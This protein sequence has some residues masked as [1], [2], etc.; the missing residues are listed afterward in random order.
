MAGAAARISR[1]SSALGWAKSRS[2]RRTA[3]LQASRLAFARS[4]SSGSSPPPLSGPM[5]GN[6]IGRTSRKRSQPSPARTAAP[7]IAEA[8]AEKLSR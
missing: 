7:S 6:S 8:V 5:R 3:F 2:R 1:S 4:A